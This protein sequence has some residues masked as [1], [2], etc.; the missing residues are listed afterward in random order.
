M[1]SGDRRPTNILTLDIEDWCQSSP[2][3]F[4][5]A[6]MPQIPAPT[7]RAVTNTRRLLGILNEY[8]A[9]ATCFVL[10]S[11]AEAYPELVREIRDSGHEVASHGYHHLP[12]QVSAWARPPEES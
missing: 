4:S 5:G 7:M 2:D 6:R 3:V 9:R 11:T 1:V 10:G 12:K 8:K